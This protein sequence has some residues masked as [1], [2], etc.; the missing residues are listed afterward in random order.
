MF[1]FCVAFGNYRVLALFRGHTYDA[2]NKLDE[3]C[4]KTNSSCLN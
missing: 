3:H 4:A 2:V 1:L